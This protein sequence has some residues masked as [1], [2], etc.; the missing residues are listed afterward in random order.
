MRR[1]LLSALS[2]FGLVFTC[3]SVNAQTT[4]ALG[5]I[6][7]TGYN[8]TTSDNFSFVILKTGGIAAGTVIKFTDRGWWG[9]APNNT[10][11]TQGWGTTVEEEVVWTA[12]VA[13]PYGRQVRIQG[14]TSYYQY[15][16]GN[17]G[18]TVTGTAL[19]LSSGGDQ[20][21]AYQGTQ[22]G[23]YTMLAGIQMNYSI[24][25]TN[26]G[27]NNWDNT[28]AVSPSG[29]QSNRPA[30]LVTGTHAIIVTQPAANADG[31]DEVDNGALK[32]QTVL[33]GN[34]A[35]DRSRVNNVANWI[36]SDVSEFTL[37]PSLSGLPVDFTWIKALD[38][39]S[40]GVSVEWGVGTEEEIKNYT[41]E[42]SDDGRLY[43]ELGVVTATGQKSYSFTDLQPANGANYY[44]IRATE[45]S[46][47][48][49]YSTIAIVNRSKGGKGIGVYP[50]I[51]R[52]NSFILQV[53]NL[54]AGSYK[55]NIHNTMGQLIM[56]RVLNHGGGSASQSINIPATTQKGVYKVSL[57]GG[58]GTN[59]TTIVVQ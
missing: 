26:A 55:L 1:S 43:V 48:T 30:C 5:D 56:S 24:G 47:T 13:I 57:T 40:G 51:V 22:T 19:N 33:S 3:V 20:I 7:F 15:V 32:Y 53:N 37:P 9:Q 39:S 17:D 23:V 35:T 52:N 54:P 50:T 41:I 29:T 49:K 46:G 45:L 10:C 58:A 6:A 36:T 31:V 38:R 16:A 4:L 34:P 59:T 25:I 12:A 21:F 27:A 14:L 42:K 8:T 11:G 18:G 44:R 28:G 2:C